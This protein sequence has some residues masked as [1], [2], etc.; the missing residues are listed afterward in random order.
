MAKAQG[1][2]KLGYLEKLEYGINFF[3]TATKHLSNIALPLQDGLKTIGNT[4]P[5]SLDRLAILQKDLD[6]AKYT[7]D[8]L[9]TTADFDGQYIFADWLNDGKLFRSSVTTAL[10]KWIKSQEDPIS[11][12]TYYHQAKSYKTDVLKNANLFFK[13][14]TDDGGSGNIMTSVQFGN[15]I[16]ALS[17]TLKNL[18]ASVA[19]FAN[20]ALAASGGFE[21]STAVQIAAIVNNGG[22][23]DIVGNGN[24][25]VDELA[26]LFSDNAATLISTHALPQRLLAQDVMQNALVQTRIISKCY[27]EHRENS[28][29]KHEVYENTPLPEG[30]VEL[31]GEYTYTEY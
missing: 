31:V 3:T 11:V 10:N 19:P 20:A 29:I 4:G 13:A 22:K 28:H 12:T 27:L 21:G 30:I 23:V 15:A 1:P 5:L 6:N 7:A 2:Q 8:L 16:F 17:P 18:L 9:I 26:S 14:V 25:N 24:N